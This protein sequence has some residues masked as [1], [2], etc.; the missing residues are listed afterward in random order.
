MADETGTNTSPIRIAIIGGGLAGATLAN[1]LV[2]IPHLRIR[3][4][5]SATI[6]SERGAAVGLSS[7]AQ[8]ALR[9]VFSPS[10]SADGEDGGRAYVADLLSRAGAVPM[11]SSRVMLGSGLQAG[12]LLAD[13]TGASDP[14]VVVHR[15]SLLRELLA[16]LGDFEGILHA[17]K[18]LAAMERITSSRSG[19]KE[20]EQ[21]RIT[22]ED[23]T[24]DAFDAV[25][26]ADGIFSRVRDYVLREPANGPKSLAAKPAGFWDCRVLVPYEKAKAVI[27]AEHFE[28]DRQFAWIGEGAFIMHDILEHRT[29]VQCVVSAVEDLEGQPDGSRKRPL[30]REFLKKTLYKWLDGPIAGGIIDLVLNQHKE[31]P[32]AYSQYHHSSTPTYS[33]GNTCIIGD[34]AH[35]TT[36]WQ[37]A[38]AG[39]AFEDAMILGTLFREVKY[40]NHISAVF[41]AYDSVRRP[42][43]QRVID[44]SWEMGRI[45]CGVAEAGLD[46]D[47]LRKAMGGKWSFLFGLDFG[48]YKKEAVEMLKDE[49]VKRK[50]A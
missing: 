34:A 31:T 43:C 41:R 15:A 22:F 8:Q 42:R 13:M 33:R 21:V 30:T 1:A 6:F 7:N 46:P 27:G 14:G 32:N 3:I 28:L 29:M 19:G 24:S 48:E 26:G 18:K 5:E 25:I 37:G 2:Q 44:S 39:Q 17:S 20:T 47:G 38:G 23:G 10:S 40:A 4:Y 12:T 45:L 35:A 9:H 49:L 16:P 36:P 50:K 11:N